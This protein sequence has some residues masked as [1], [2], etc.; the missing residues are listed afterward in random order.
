M[1]GNNF[2]EPIIN[3]NERQEPP[4]HKNDIPIVIYDYDFNN[5]KTV[6]ENK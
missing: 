1:T 2:D 6:Y 3:E 5:I 4:Y